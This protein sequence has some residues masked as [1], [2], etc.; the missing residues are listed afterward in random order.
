MQLNR[1]V[2]SKS[3]TQDD[4][5]LVEITAGDDF[6][7]LCDKKVN[8]NTYPS[9]DGYWFIGIFDSRKRPRVNR[10]AQ[11]CAT[12]LQLA[13]VFIK[14]L[15][16]LLLCKHRCCHVSRLASQL[17]CQ[18][19]FAKNDNSF[20]GAWEV[21]ATYRTAQV[22]PVRVLFSVHL[23][24]FTV[25]FTFSLAEYEDM[26]Y[27]SGFCDG[28]AV[29]VAFEHQHHYKNHRILTGSVYA[30]ARYRYTSRIS[31]YSQARG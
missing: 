9:L 7:G 11:G 13:C 27:V 23:V 2:A 4:L 14:L 12:S 30:V 28:H 25:P 3:I 10:A 26:V 15:A 5:W 21:K 6:L 24:T 22:S 18:S 29:S 1:P 17:T 19:K 16:Y 20:V 8:I 31:R